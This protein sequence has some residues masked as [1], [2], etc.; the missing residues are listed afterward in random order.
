[1]QALVVPLIFFQELPSLAS[2][3]KH[4]AFVGGNPS[5]KIVKEIPAT[6]HGSNGPGSVGGT[7]SN[8]KEI[9]GQTS[10]FDIYIL[11]FSNPHTS[12]Q[13]HKRHRERTALWDRTSFNVGPPY[14]FGDL[15]PD[16][17]VVDEL[18]KGGEDST[19]HSSFKSK[20]EQKLPIN[21]IKILKNID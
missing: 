14:G 18:E 10:G 5:T 8:E 21:L 2:S 3:G 12:D 15:K 20:L 1:M 4:E 16:L 7:T 9:V 19:G 11:H 6:K 17:Q 13:C